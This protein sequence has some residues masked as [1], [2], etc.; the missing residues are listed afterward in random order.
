M[1]SADSLTEGMAI[2]DENAYLVRNSY[3]VGHVLA[4]AGD[5]ASASALLEFAWQQLGHRVTVMFPADAAAALTVIR[6]YAGDKDNVDELLAAIRD[7][8]GRKSDAGIYEY[9]RPDGC[10]VY[11]EG[12]AAYLSGQHERGLTLIG[13]AVEDGYFVFPNEA[14][15]QTLYDD[16]DFAPILAVQ[17]DRQKRERDK[18]LAIVCS[19]NPYTAVWQPEDETCGR[20]AT[21]SGN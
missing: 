3:I 4:S 5:Y 15:L 12:L 9:C 20:F 19:D 13:K 8:V 10:P 14:Y 7:D 11:E 17:Q 21:E 6:R 18:F 1:L 2:I 16:P